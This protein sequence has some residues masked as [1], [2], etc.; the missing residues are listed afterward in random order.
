MNT[1]LSNKKIAL[2]PNSFWF[3]RKRFQIVLGLITS[4]VIPFIIIKIIFPNTI[5]ADSQI[6]ISLLSSGSAFLIGWAIFQNTINFPGVNR[7]QQ[8]A[9][10][11]VLSYIVVASVLFFLRLEFSRVIY[12]TSFVCT[13][14]GFLFVFYSIQKRK[15]LVFQVVPFGNVSRLNRINQAYWIKMS[16]PDLPKQ[17]CTAIV[18]DMRADMPDDWKRM[19]AEAALSGRPVFHFKQLEEALTGHV[20]IE[21]ISENSLGALY[22]NS[23]ATEFKKMVDVLVSILVL[24]PLLPLMIF[25]AIAI[26]LESPGSV[27]FRQKRIG[28]YGK[29]FFVFKFRSMF[30][31]INQIDNERQSA[32]TQD[33]DARIT[34][35]GMVI[36]RL[37]IDELPQ[38]FNILRGEMSWV[39]PRPEAFHLSAW[40][41]SEIPFY[42]YRH[43]LKPGITGWAQINQGHVADLEAVH[44]KLK[45][46]FYY[47]KH[48]SIWL[49]IVIL[50]RTAY[51]VVTGFGA[52]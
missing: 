46:D 10:L 27:I 20:D 40:Y 44:D 2:S 42:S 29:P 35:V 50:M 9:P 30:T 19:L 22:P 16:S 23:S 3:E 32:I 8:I 39:G 15:T 7:V 12:V 43:I 41:H 31:D 5:F 36:R 25:V 14:V 1:L 17:N 52:R 48:F 4:L 47:I 37:R 33:N 24:P 13:L 21:H 51:I 45:L 34:R 49:D 38:L 28:Q 26:K 6:Q 18:A 11:L